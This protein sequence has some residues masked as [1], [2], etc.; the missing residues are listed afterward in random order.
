[1]KKKKRGWLGARWH[2]VAAA[3]AAAVDTLDNTEKSW[4]GLELAA[5]VELHLGVH[6]LTRRLM[7]LLL[8]LLLLQK[9]KMSQKESNSWSQRRRQLRPH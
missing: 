2:V 5:A 8:L 3:A 6:E 7:L 9:K 1:M 4:V